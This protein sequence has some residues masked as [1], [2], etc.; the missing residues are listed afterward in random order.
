V[1]AGLRHRLEHVRA[2]LVGELAQLLSL[3]GAQLR[4]IVDR[5]Q[6]LVHRWVECILRQLAGNRVH[7]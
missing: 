4:R 3:E 5:L 6:E 2:K 7:D 1:A